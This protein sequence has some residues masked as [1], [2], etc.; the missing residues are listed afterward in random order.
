MFTE[1]FPRIIDN[2]ANFY[3]DG[4]KYGVVFIVTA[5]QTN[6][7]RS[8][9]MQSFNHLICLQIP[10]ESDYRSLLGCP[11][12][13]TPSKYFGRGL[14]KLE[15]NTYEFQTAL[16]VERSQINNVVRMSAPKLMEAY[17]GYKVPPVPSVPD[18]V[19]VDLLLPHLNNL[20]NVPV[21]YD[22]DTKQITTF[23]FKKGPFT[24]ILTGV[25]DVEKI[26]FIFGLLKLLTKM[27]GNKV[28]VIDF[29]KAYDRVVEGVTAYT[30]NFDQAIIEMN[31]TVIKEKDNLDNNI[32]V[33]LGIG[34]YKNKINEGA[35][36]VMNQLF[37]NA[38]QYT[39]AH[40][41]FIDLYASYKNVQLEPWYQSKIDN[42]NGIWL[43]TDAGSQMAIS[44]TDLTMDDR[45][46]NFKDMAFTVDGGKRKVI[47]H[48]VDPEENNE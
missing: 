19:T 45:K 26:Y 41:I 46:L 16:F 34:E 33:I 17:K 23:N 22:I 12:G 2:V 18:T 14:I 11:R 7:I 36:T 21:G 47:R 10:N 31:N 40:F 32:Y 15:D 29:V 24:T 6:A 48:V 20:T 28:H 35:R 8:R 3:R 39:N 9:V 27:E 5:I 44:I 37:M 4:S 1:T 25:M 13:L 38:D 42:S 30:D 43:G